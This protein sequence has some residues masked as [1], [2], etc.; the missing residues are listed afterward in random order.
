MRDPKRTR[1]D[2]SPSA[3]ALRVLEAV[4]AD[5]PAMSLQA[6]LDRLVI[7]GGWAHALELPAELTHPKR[8]TRGAGSGTR[9]GGVPGGNAKGSGTARSLQWPPLL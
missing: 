6:A 4:R 7:L 1:I 9:R 5:H 8:R 2:Y 3:A